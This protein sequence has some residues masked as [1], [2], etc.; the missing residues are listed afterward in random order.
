MVI[1]SPISLPLLSSS[2]TTLVVLPSEVTLLFLFYLKSAA[3]YVLIV[4]TRVA[5]IKEKDANK[6]KSQFLA[7]V[8]HGMF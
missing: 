6:A 7:N 5:L 4:F 3:L 1:P 2:P 8:S